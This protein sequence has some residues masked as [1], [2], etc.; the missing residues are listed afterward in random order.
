MKKFVATALSAAMVVSMA[1]SAYAETDVGKVCYNVTGAGVP[2]AGGTLALQVDQFGNEN[3]ELHGYFQVPA[4]AACGLAAPFL[5]QIPV[6]GSA[7]FNGTTV[8][9]NV[10][11]SFHSVGVTG[12]AGS[13]CA[14]ADYAM[15]INAS[16]LLPNP[17]TNAVMTVDNGAFTPTIFT[18]T[19]ANSCPSVQ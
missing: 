8:P 5:R 6:V 16:T 18:L 19:V 14:P 4:A 7:T 11:V 12:T 1:A 13:A 2:T 10:A 15:I 17:A 3:F 9:G